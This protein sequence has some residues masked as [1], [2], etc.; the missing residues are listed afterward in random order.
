MFKTVDT[1]RASVAICLG[2]NDELSDAFF[3]EEVA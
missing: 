3:E 1:H 2:F